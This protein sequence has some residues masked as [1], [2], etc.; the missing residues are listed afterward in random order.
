[1]SSKELIPKESV[2]ELLAH[3]EKAL[4]EFDAGL[5]HLLAAHAAA[6]RAAGGD[7]HHYGFDMSRDRHRTVYAS[8]L[9][10][11]AFRRNVDRAIWRYLLEAS[12]IRAMMGSEDLKRWREQLDTED[13]PEATW[14]TIASTLAGLA[15]SVP[16]LIETTAVSCFKRL[17]WHYKTN[18]PASF[19]PRIIYEYAYDPKWPTISRHDGFGLLLHDLERLMRIFDGKPPSED[20]KIV[21]EL[22][23]A[24]PKYGEKPESPWIA[25]TE[26]FHVKAFKKGTVHLKFKRADLLDKL[27]MVLAKHYGETLPEARS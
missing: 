11:D 3:R 1:M 8:H 2:A 17:R 20:C 25:E 12:G 27:N 7:P 14:E 23:L 22:Q 9:D 13:V 16:G 15:G 19:T 24:L 10:R 4:E 6:E 5:E 21:G 26:Y 18:D